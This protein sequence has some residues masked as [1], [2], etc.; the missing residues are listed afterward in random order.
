[1]AGHV[2]V[3]GLVEQEFGIRITPS[4]PLQLLLLAWL[5]V[6]QL[7]R[8]MNGNDSMSYVFTRGVWKKICRLLENAFS[9]GNAKVAHGSGT[10]RLT[11][12]RR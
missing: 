2:D 4:I 6:D 5:I 8:L 11:R 9:R 7:N 12:I 1:M 3:T 10:R